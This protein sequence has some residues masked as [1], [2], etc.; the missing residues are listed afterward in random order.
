MGGQFEYEIHI[1]NLISLATK[2]ILSFPHKS[3]KQKLTS[4]PGIYYIDSAGSELIYPLPLPIARPLSKIFKGL[5][6]Y[7]CYLARKDETNP[8]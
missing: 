5:C 3:F 6:A 1:R 8:S 4:L 2:H 7:V